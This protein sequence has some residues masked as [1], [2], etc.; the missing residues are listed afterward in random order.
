MIEMRQLE[1]VPAIIER[2]AGDILYS[3]GMQSERQ[4]IQH[5]RLSCYEHSLHVTVMSIRLA[6]FFGLRVDM[7]SLVRGALLHDYF[8][9][10]WHQPHPSHK[11]HAYLHAGR[12]LKNA[13]ESFALN[14][15]ERDIIAKHMF[16]INLEPPRYKES[17]LVCGA[18]KLC[19]LIEVI[20]RRALLS[21]SL[22]AGGCL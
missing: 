13:T 6:R 7:S 10:D 17:L 3:A 14:D 19:T 5:A 11:G 4:Y 18:D 8:L 9:Y 16:P 15:I 1:T 21:E 20:G 22:R 12:A 2:Y